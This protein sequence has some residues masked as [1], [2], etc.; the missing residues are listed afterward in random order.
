MYYIKG[1]RL[2]EGAF[3]SVFC[4]IKK[5]TKEKRAIKIIDKDRIRGEYMKEYFR[6]ISDEEMKM[7]INDLLKIK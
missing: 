4:A 3:G 5:D 7:H 1:E 2:G 6:S